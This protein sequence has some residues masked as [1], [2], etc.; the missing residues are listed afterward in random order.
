MEIYFFLILFNLIL[1]IYNKSFAK[2]FNLYDSPNVERKI[3]KSSVPITGGLIIFFNFFIFNFYNGVALGSNLNSN[4]FLFTST[5]LFLLGVIDD[6]FDISSNI[7]FLL[8]ILII[9][10]IVYL[11]Q[12]LQ[13]DI[14]RL[15]FLDNEY[16]IGK[17]GI[18]WS[19]LCLLL[20]INA[21]NMFDG[22]N[23]QVGL[24]SIFVSIFVI[25]ININPIFFIFI[26]VGILSFLFLNFK[27]KSFLGDGGTYLIAFIIGYYFIAMYDSKI[28]YYADQIV[29][30]MVIPGYD[31]MRLFTIRILN[32]KNPFSADKNH[33]HHLLLKKFSYY[34]VIAIIQFLIFVPII[35][36]LIFGYTL[37]F[38][39]ISLIIYTFIVY[40]LS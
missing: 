10:P 38:I 29:L 12:G 16:N 13:L 8:L 9:F 11:E 39:V 1:I 28:I 23:L 27:S 25:F 6:K 19:V 26:S 34:E 18:V 37:F 36:N 30:F 31:L 24:Y 32:K 17:L 40:R 3:H 14:I 35:L 21:L 22:I 4:L 15:S 5:I 33:L 7:K 20:F 2:F